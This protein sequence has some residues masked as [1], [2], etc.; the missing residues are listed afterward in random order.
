MFTPEHRTHI[1]TTL[2]EEAA[3]DRRIVGAAITGSAAAGRED[4]WSD[5]DLAFGVIDAAEIPNVLSDWTNRMYGCHQALHHL[6]VRAGNWIYRVFLLPGT[7]QVDLAFVVADEFRPLAPTFHLVFGTA[8]EPMN[9]SPPSPAD[10]IGWGWLYAVHARTCL[11]RRRFWQ[12]EY[13]I[14]SIRDSALTLACIRHG[15]PTVHG[16]GLDLLPDEVSRKFESSLIRRLDAQEI[17]RAFRVVTQ[18]Y[19]DEISHVDAELAGR[20]QSAFRQMNEHCS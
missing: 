16:R 12:A 13:M 1:R 19:L 3:K 5:I 7:L 17:A 4:Q 9:G 14:S 11:A 6:D 10:I 20:L 8:G 2:L 15:L 18:G